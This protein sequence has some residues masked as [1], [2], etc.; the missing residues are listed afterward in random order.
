MAI[1]KDEESIKRL[2]KL[3]SL[4]QS[5]REM[6]AKAM[7]FISSYDFEVF[8][9]K[10]NDR[11]KS[12]NNKYGLLNNSKVSITNFVETTLMANNRKSNQGKTM[13]VP[14]DGGDDTGGKNCDIKRR[15]C[16]ILS[17]SAAVAGHLACLAFM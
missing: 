13:V 4:N 11:I 15:N 17:N 9:K 10:Q 3:T 7:G 6:F 12:V 5:E 14:S 1:K 8:V 16:L 2:M